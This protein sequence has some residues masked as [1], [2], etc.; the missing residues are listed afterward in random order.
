M[1]RVCLVTY[2]GSPN[3]GAALQLFATYKAIRDLNCSVSVINYQNKFESEKTGLKYLFSSASIKEKAREYISSYFFGVKKNSKRNFSEFYSQMDYTQKITSVDEI[4]KIDGYDVFC[5]GSDQVWNPRITDGFDDVFTLNSSDIPRKIS[6]ASSMGSCDFKGYSDK[7]F[8]N[9]VEK[10]EYISVRERIAKEYLESRTDKEIA[11]VVDPTFLLGYDQWNACIENSE[12]NSEA[13]EKYVLIY[14]LGGYFE[15]NKNVAVE[16][17]NRI[18]AKVYSITLSNRKK[19]VDRIITD[20]T[21][22]DFVRYIRDASFV[23]T[24]SFHGTC[25]SINLKV[26]FYSVRFGD[27]PARAEELLDMYGLSSRL[28]RHGNKI[29]ETLLNNNDIIRAQESI[30]ENARKSREWLRKAIY[31]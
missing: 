30:D 21:P 18:G 26:P 28:Y 6:Y 31:E 13:K 27:N 1:K 22:I 2:T 7:D 12:S 20:A 9:A 10:F 8:I 4:K 25:F 29:D 24:N 14:A 19:G 5:V 11:Q 17:A 16:I 15:E 23:V 3:Y